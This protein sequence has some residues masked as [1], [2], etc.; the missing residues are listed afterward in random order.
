MNLENEVKNAHNAFSKK[1]YLEAANQFES[2]SGYYY[3]LKDLHN[4]AEMSNNASVA[5]LLGGNAQKAYDVAKDTHLVFERE[6]DWKNCGMALGNQA[7]AAEGLGEKTRALDLYQQASDYLHNAGDEES[8]AYV[9]KKISALQIQQGK[10]LEALLN[11]TTA[12]NNLPELSKR[13][14]LLKKLTDLVMKIGNR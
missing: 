11:M 2:I 3:N 10:Q 4:S 1:Q 13:E 7:A 12:L 5:F 8:R 14:K 9:L 6:N